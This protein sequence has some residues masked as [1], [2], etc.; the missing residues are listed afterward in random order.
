MGRVHVGFMFFPSCC[1]WIILKGVVS[2]CLSQG[3]WKEYLVLN[4]LKNRLFP[5][6]IFFFWRAQSTNTFLFLRLMCCRKSYSSH[7]LI[8]CVCVYIH[9]Y[10][11]CASVPW[12]ELGN[13]W[14][15][16][17]VSV[18]MLWLSGT[19][20]VWGPCLRGWCTWKRKM[21]I[22]RKYK[23]P[24]FLNDCSGCMQ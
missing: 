8:L 1:C 21:C 11:V 24:L 6:P 14:N 23:L 12:E 17:Y 15:W 9:I 7:W 18:L 4:M 13:S 5:L 20:E 10:S 22:K 2:I 3:D 19:S 16:N